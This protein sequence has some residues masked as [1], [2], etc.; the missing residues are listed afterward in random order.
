MTYIALLRGINVGGHKLIKMEA[1]RKSLERLPFTNV[2]TYIQSGNILFESPNE[3][4]AQLQRSIAEIIKMDFGFE[5]PVVI[6]TLDELNDVVVNNPYSERILSD[7]AQPY[8]S[9]LSEIPTRERVA[10]LK[11]VDF[12]NDEFTVY[13]RW[14]YILYESAAKT[15]LSNVVIERKLNLQSTARNWKTVHK[16]IELSQKIV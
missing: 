3:D 9:F 6:V 12:G 14:L 8:I 15:K 4:S 11:E 13:K 7:P 16:L 2:S 5:V 10:T 1:L